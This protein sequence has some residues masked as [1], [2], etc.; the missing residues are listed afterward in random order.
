MRGIGQNDSLAFADPGVGVYIDDVFVA[1]S[2][3]AFLELFDVERVEVLRGPQATL[4][5]RNTI[6]GAIKCVSK[7]PPDEFGAYLEAG[8]G[9]FD[10]ATVKGSLGGPIKPGVLR[11]KAAFSFARRDGFNTNTQTGEDDG[12]LTSFAG[13]GALLY[14]PSEDLEFLLSV[15]G[16]VDRPDTSRSPVRETSIAGAPDPIGAPTNSSFSREQRSV[17]RR[18]QRQRAFRSY[19]LRRGAHRAPE[20][21]R[22]ADH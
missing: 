15:D 12:D 10:F 17:P 21:Q 1:R 20:D 22:R 14:T 3:A 16:K 6:G 9:N 18:R 4:Y 7:T 8:G 2:Q 19:G 5:G 11:G 13:R